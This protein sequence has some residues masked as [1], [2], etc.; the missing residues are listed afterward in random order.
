MKI[1]VLDELRHKYSLCKLLE[2][3]NIPRSTYYYWLEQARNNIDK[4]KELK[5]EIKSIFN[6]HKGR[7]GYRRIRLELINRGYIVNHKKVSRLMKEMDLS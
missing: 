7:Y 5:E 1:R 3:A 2:L 4:D 6:E